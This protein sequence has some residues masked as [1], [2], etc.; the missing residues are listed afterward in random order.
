MSQKQV[1]AG[2]RGLWVLIATLIGMAITARAGFWQLDRAAQKVA[3]QAQIDT[4]SR[5]P[6][7]TTGDLPDDESVAAAQYQRRVQLQGQWLNDQTVYLDNRQMAGRP[8]FYVLTPLRL[9][10]GRLLLV[11]RGWAP[12]DAA[13]RAHLPALPLQTGDLR[14]LGRLVAWP[15]RLAQLGDDA[16]GAI[17]QNIDRD[18]LARRL[19]APVLPYSVQQLEPAE[20]A[21]EGAL[22]PADGLGRDWPQTA[23]DVGKHYSYAAQWFIFCAMM[24]GLYVWFQLLRPWRARH[25]D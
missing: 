7:W 20:P 10:D 1:K 3:L 23:L 9:P 8:G 22:A 18:E 4:Q 17:R 6:A 19:R 16:P 25:A 5:A 24:A 11:Q 21:A 12:R 2:A 15:S 14:L 13:D